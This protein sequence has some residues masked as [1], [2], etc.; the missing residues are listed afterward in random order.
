MCHLFVLVQ[1]DHPGNDASSVSTK[2]TRCNSLPV[3]V[4]Q[5]YARSM[6]GSLFISTEYTVHGALRRTRTY[7]TDRRA[8]AINPLARWPSST[9]CMHWYRVI[10]TNSITSASCGR[11]AGGKIPFVTP[12]HWMMLR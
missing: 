10:G 8:S 3:W 7:A 4:L 2:Y 12:K 11:V 5:T 9:R 6:S 1:I